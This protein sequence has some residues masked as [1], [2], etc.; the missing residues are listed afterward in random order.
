MSEAS[1]QV[2]PVRDAR[3]LQPVRPVFAAA[4]LSLMILAVLLS[5]LLSPDSMPRTQ[6]IFGGMAAKVGVPVWFFVSFITAV[7]WLPLPF[8]FWHLF[9]IV[10][11]GAWEGGPISGFGMLRSVF[12]VPS[13]HPDLKAAR[14]IVIL[15]LG[16]Y[17]V[18][19][20]SYAYIA[21]E[22][23]LKQKLETERAAQLRH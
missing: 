2:S 20:F 23:D 4:I 5:V 15:V 11:R 18:A 14:L 3:W 19:M 12:T 6:E 21:D 10:F 13:R 8:A 22:R 1:H 7:A 17:L 9:R 16:S